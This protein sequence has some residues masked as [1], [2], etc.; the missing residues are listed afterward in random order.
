MRPSTYHD[1][2][3]FVTTKM[4][5]TAPETKRKV[6]ADIQALRAIA[7]V[8]VVLDHLVLL[9]RLPGHPEGGFIGVD[10][11][12]VISG[13]LITQHLV[14]EEFRNGRVS[15]RQFY[16]RRVRRILPMAVLVIAVT[17]GASFAVFWPWQA[18][19]FALDGLWSAL[20][21]SNIA[22]AVRGVDYFASEQV[23]IFQ[24]YW[25]LSVEEQFYLA[26]PVLIAVTGYF[27]LR[28]DRPRKVF[29]AVALAVAVVSL[30]W[31][32]VETAASPTT[33]YFST[34][35]R[36]FEFA[37]G[38][39]V[40]VLA[41]ALRRFPR[42]PRVWASS[43][44]VLGI[45]ASV[46]LVDPSVGFPGPMALL[47]VICTAAVI[48]AGTGT[49]DNVAPW[50]LATRPVTYTGDISYSL[51][52]WHWPVIMFV[53]AFVPRDQVVVP[54]AL[55]LSFGL[56]A[57]SYRCVERPI[58]ASSWLVPNR[59]PS[60]GGRSSAARNI[61]AMLV[62]VL[63]T[64]AMIGGGD[65]AVRA[66]AA[67]RTDPPGGALILQAQSPQGAELV[68]DIQRLIDDSDNRPDWSGLKP[69]I[70]DLASYGGDL[71]QECWTE[72]E[73]QPRTCL[74]G[75]PHAAH[76]I[77][78]LGDSIAMN[79][80]FS[81]D[82]FVR[83]H[84]DWNMSVYAK[85]GCAAPDVPLFAQNGAEYV[86][87][88]EFRDWAID[89]ILDQKPDAVWIT[90]AVP[91]DL[92]GTDESDMFDVWADGLSATIAR[93]SSVPRVFVVT[94]PPAGQDLT[95]CSRPFNVPADCA[96]VVTR[97]WIEN[98]DVFQLA[99]ERQGRTFVDTGMWFCDADGYCPAVIGDYIVRRDE[100]HL[101]YDFG[102][103]LA[104]LVAAWVED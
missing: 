29:L 24:H 3:S 89:Q 68:D 15:F 39:V 31:A 103:F 7:V 74:R 97:P 16:I 50:P 87:C 28:R 41:P 38:G 53:T 67:S 80:A 52:L 22:F 37:V 84:P 46:W 32:C 79:A 23:S 40:A 11:F 43:L 49:D 95:F 92:L 76:S 26:W 45:A 27:A 30:A 14:S 58:L 64:A 86:A 34:F 61:G 55:V 85:L 101:T 93:L 70:S 99:A 100:R 65:A 47:P 20:F 1:G 60:P 62:G 17:V 91:R 35:C 63:L 33:A 44:G 5:S 75:N 56:A 10:V 4:T 83:R 71:S 13:F 54:A 94:P 96:S 25:S 82:E 51:Y 81:V 21:V 98:R 8:L 2:G 77:A 69:D 102:A 59:Q 6:R 36:A 48:A 90:S 73:E 78:V 18:K 12:F 57:L 19:S 88:D 104:P 72:A 42:G 9:Q 66:V